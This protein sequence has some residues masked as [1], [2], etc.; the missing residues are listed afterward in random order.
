VI[1]D[2]HCHAGKGNPSRRAVAVGSSGCVPAPRT[3]RGNPTDDRVRAAPFADD[4]ASAN[5]TVAAVVGRYRPRLVGAVWINTRRDAGQVAELVAVG[6]GRYGFRGIKVHRHE[7]GLTCE[8]L[9]AAREFEVP[10]VYDPAS[11]AASI[12]L[13]AAEYPDVSMIIAHLGSFA[14]DWQTYQL[15]CDQAVR[16]ANVFADSSGVR[17]FDYLVQLVRRAGPRKL[18][19]GC[20]GPYLHP[21][22]ELAKIR[23]LGL[24]PRDEALSWA[25]TRG[26][27]SD[28]ITSAACCS[29]LGVAPARARP[30]DRVS[31]GVDEVP[32]VVSLQ[33]DRRGRCLLLLTG[34]ILR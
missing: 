21:G 22:V 24:S 11:R 14:D 33:I 15:V 28:S 25:A 29:A 13:A 26:G 7:H 18:V 16:H 17:R 3:G 27:C 8:V 34:G 32:H 6:V 31:G 10:I 23:L 4:S 30:C 9:D 1:V 19:F 12:D 2:A 20:D 5:R